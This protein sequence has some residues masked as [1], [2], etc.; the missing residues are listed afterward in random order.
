VVTDAPFDLTEVFPRGKYNVEIT[1]RPENGP[2]WDSEPEEGF[3]VLSQQ[4]FTPLFA[5]F[6]NCAQGG[7]HN[8][9]TMAGGFPLTDEDD[10][11][12]VLTTW[13][14]SD[15]ACIDDAEDPL[16]LVDAVVQPAVGF[17][18]G[19]ALNSVLYSKVNPDDKTLCGPSVAPHSMDFRGELELMFDWI[20][21]GAAEGGQ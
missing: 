7:C 10:S 3:E 8:D 6:P 2:A 11:Y 4:G 5:T 21:D 20:E 13:E 12:D 16:Y 18:Y 1:V 19:D 15:P 9:T 14:S 17:P